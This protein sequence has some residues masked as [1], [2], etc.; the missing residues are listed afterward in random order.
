MWSDSGRRL[1]YS[2]CFGH[3]LFVLRTH[4]AALNQAERSD[5]LADA[6]LVNRYLLGID[7][8]DQAATRV[9]H[10]NFQKYF[11]GG[12]PDYDFGIGDSLLSDTGSDQQ[13]CR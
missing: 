1:R 7:F 8:L 11:A 9:A 13:D 6:V 4:L 2:R 3:L 5:L 12:T 10:D